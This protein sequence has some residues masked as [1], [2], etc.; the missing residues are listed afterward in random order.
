MEGD[1]EGQEVDVSEVPAAE[2]QDAGAAFG[3][4][5]TF[6][7]QDEAPT[8][9][10]PTA[11]PAAP[12]SWEESPLPAGH[13]YADKYKSL[14][15]F[16]KAYEASSTEG[17]RLAQE[18]RA[19]NERLQEYDRRLQSLQTPPQQA[20]AAKE[21]D[22]WFG[23]RDKE[24]FQFS[25]GRDPSGTLNKVVEYGAV[26]SP[27]VQERIQ[28][29]I[30]SEL[31]GAL[32]PYEEARRGE[33]IKAQ[34]SHVEAQYELGAPN[35]PMREAAKN[36]VYSTPWLGDLQNYLHESHPEQNIPEV[37]VKLSTYDILKQENAALKK[38]L[39]TQRTQADVARPG[40]GG[41]ATVKLD[42]SHESILAAAAEEVGGVEPGMMKA[43]LRALKKYSPLTHKP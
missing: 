43:A 25:M 10:Q 29:A 13:P 20:P 34:M 32:A 6:H 37:V 4:G 16:S 41:K 14:G 36:F 33:L 21:V 12:V 1:E 19:Y 39:V 2:A 27:V 24:A 9:E 23:F 28:Q 8:E 11:E 40:S 30:R 7:D 22:P 26:N 42:G 15:E 3:M 35:S 38:K 17:R 18:T 31:G 5:S